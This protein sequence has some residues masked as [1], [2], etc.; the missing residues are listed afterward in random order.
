MMISVSSYNWVCMIHNF[1]LTGEVQKR[2]Q[3]R[4]KKYQGNLHSPEQDIDVILKLH[5]VLPNAEKKSVASREVTTDNYKECFMLIKESALF[6]FQSL[7]ITHDAVFEE[8]TQP[9]MIGINNYALYMYMNIYTSNFII[10]QCAGIGDLHELFRDLLEVMPNWFS[11]GIFLRINDYLL[12]AI[13]MDNHNRSRDCLR[14]MLA[15]WLRGGSASPGVLVQ[16]LISAGYFE[17]GKKMAVKH[18]ED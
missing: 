18:G 14:E 13:R 16:A 17:L 10:R 12:E 9:D 5:L 11:V 1:I 15:T 4:L 7:N 6:E 3:D 2:L 8:T